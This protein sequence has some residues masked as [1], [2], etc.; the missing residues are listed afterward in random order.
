MREK[1][2]MQSITTLDYMI[3]KMDMQICLFDDLPRKNK[4]FKLFFTRYLRWN[5][6][7]I[8]KVVSIR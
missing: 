1:G 6:S 5:P 7:L 3:T 8:I 4:D 2:G